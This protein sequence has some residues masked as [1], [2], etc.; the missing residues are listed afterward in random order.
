MNLEIQMKQDPIVPILLYC[1]SSDKNHLENDTL[2]SRRKSA[3]HGTRHAT[4][5]RLQ[6]QPLSRAMLQKPLTYSLSVSLDAAK[7]WC[8][9][10]ATGLFFLLK[11]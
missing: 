8:I 6:V 10:E 3:A 2:F 9:S 1:F 11:S 7:W 4:L 5:H